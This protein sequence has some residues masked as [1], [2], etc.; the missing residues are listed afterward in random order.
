MQIQS[1]L[2]H[3]SNRVLVGFI[4]Q[5]LF[6]YQPIR[7]FMNHNPKLQMNFESESCLSGRVRRLLTHVSSKEKRAETKKVVLP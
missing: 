7:R 1:I 4:K 3:M 2:N 6:D 5:Y